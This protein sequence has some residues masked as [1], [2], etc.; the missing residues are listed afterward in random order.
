MKK[1]GL[2]F[3]VC[4]ALA[5]PAP[6][7]AETANYAE[8]PEAKEVLK[9]VRE[10]GLDEER[11][12]QLLAD[13]KRK[14]SI[15]EAIAR[16]A[17]R[18]LTWAEYSRIFLQE[19]RVRQGVAFA[20]EHAEALDRAERE[21]RIPR[22]IILAI[23]GV[24]T[25]YGRHKGS[26]RVLDAL[27]TL[28]FDYPPRGAFFRKQ[29]VAL[30][31]MERDAHIDAGTITGSYAGAMGF[32]QFIPTSYEAY[33]VDFD[34]DGV[35]DLVNSPVDAIGSVANYFKQHRW[36]PGLPVA[37]RARVDGDGYVKMAEAGYKPSFTLDQARKNG[38]VAL[39]CGDDRL[40]SQYC[41][42]TSE[43]GLPGTQPVAVL[44][45]TGEDGHE[46]WLATD[47]FYVITR[48][49]HSELYAMAVLQLS[50]RIADALKDAR[51]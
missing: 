28:G 32:P 23:I 19:D 37:A 18:T 14:D 6:A 43:Q 39:S 50:H 24:E 21:Y 8:H 48:Y 40:S 38:V 33:A 51:P 11:V 30:F 35:I 41:F 42:D 49:N 20:E 22:E 45:L 44:D 16:P 17:E 13:A 2:L 26:Y 7:W 10:N 5:G 12:R 29:L 34:G 47:N 46:F 4:A 1:T 15:L 27:T 3:A 9:A 31:K 36:Q 25:R